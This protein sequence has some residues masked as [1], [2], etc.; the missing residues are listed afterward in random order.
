MSFF[1]FLK[2]VY[3]V[4]KSRSYTNIYSFLFEFLF[5]FNYYLD[6]KLVYAFS[7]GYRIILFFLFCF[8]GFVPVSFIGVLDPL[9][10]YF[11]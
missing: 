4:F 6:V 5:A 3:C 8:L 9:Q 7:G 1:Q 11:V 10:I 2:N